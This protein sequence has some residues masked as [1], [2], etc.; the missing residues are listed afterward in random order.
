METW[1]GRAHRWLAGGTGGK[2][3]AWRHDSALRRGRAVTVAVG[4]RCG[5]FGLLLGAARVAGE[6]CYRCADPRQAWGLRVSAMATSSASRAP[7]PSTAVEWRGEG[8]GREEEERGKA[9]RGSVC[10]GESGECRGRRPAWG[11]SSPGSRAPVEGTGVRSV[12]VTAG[13]TWRAFGARSGW[14]GSEASRRAPVRSRARSRAHPAIAARGAAWG[15]A[16]AGVTRGHPRA[17]VER[18]RRSASSGRKTEERGRTEVG[19]DAISDRGD[20]KEQRQ[21]TFGPCLV[22]SNSRI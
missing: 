18:F 22:A 6:G 8:R 3:V 15:R 21:K 9:K 13:A 10:G 19:D 17:S 5:L 1:Q 16:R 20:G 2:A 11:F 7:V 4:V 14:P 12:D